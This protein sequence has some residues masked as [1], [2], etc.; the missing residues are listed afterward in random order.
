MS[1]RPPFSNP[2]PGLAEIKSRQSLKGIEAKSL[3]LSESETKT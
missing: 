2:R 3:S 1:S